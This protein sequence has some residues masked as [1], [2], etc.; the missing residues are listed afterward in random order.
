MDHSTTPPSERAVQDFILVLAPT[1]GDAALSR[2]LLAEARFEAR[3]YTDVGDFCRAY[4]DGVGALLLTEDLMAK[5]SEL[6][7]LLEL[8]HAQPTWSD[9]PIL[10]LTDRGA[11]SPAA[12]SAMELLGN[13]IVLERPVRITTLVSALRTALKA[14]RR[15]YELRDQIEALSRSVAER[16]VASDELRKHTHRLRLLWEA[17]SVLLT[18][19]EPDAMLRGLFHRIARDLGVDL[20]LNYMV[21]ESG[22]NLRLESS[23]GLTEDDARRM[24]TLKFG[25]AVCGTVALQRRPITATFVQQSN[26]PLVQVF[27]GL[28]VRSYTSNPLL[29][30]ERLLGTLAFGSRTRDRFTVEEIEFTK[31]ICQYVSTAYERARLVRSLRDGDRHKDEFLA[32]LAHELRNPLAPIRNGLQVLRLAMHD[33]AAVEQALTMMER[34]LGQMIRLIDDL[35][36]LNRISRGK[37]ELKQERIDLAE[38]VNRAVETS[39]PL[40]DSRNHTLTVE[41]PEGA[42]FVRGDAA[43][44]AQVFANLLNNAAKYTEPGGQIRF[45]VR[46]RDGE[47]EASIRDDGV[48]ISR[49][50]LPHVFDLF[51][52]ADGSLQRS[53][54]GLGIGLTLVKKLVELHGGEVEARSEGL[55]RGTEI[56]VRLPRVQGTSVSNVIDAQ[57]PGV[58]APHSQLRILV[59]DDN[60]DSADTLAM[61]LQ[62]IGNDVRTGHDGAEAI[63]TA[64]TFRPDV[65]LLDLGMPNVNGFDACRAIRSRPWARRA[66]IIAMTGWGQEE[67]RRKTRDAGFDH[68]LVKPVDPAGLMK[69]LA[70]LH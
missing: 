49:E 3:V 55:G 13:V 26:D 20:C 2:S 43:R 48:G 16:A 53:Q 52:Q 27:K 50:M 9:V 45:A 44:L 4:D 10:M 56:V 42:T 61:M 12:L 54:G 31:T 57:Q 34:Q 32:T 66:V 15:Q 30:D 69:L 17:A 24:E 21:D 33:P 59:A 64:E 63:E 68:H 18:S 51:A 23:M 37:I 47:V 58:A 65:V 35:L 41:P 5:G 38:V 7:C 40:I 19:E 14:R 60:R 67:D 70:E 62:I 46:R 8:L 36:D 39:R 28:G 1:T 22:E 29:A 11:D 25:Q 6:T